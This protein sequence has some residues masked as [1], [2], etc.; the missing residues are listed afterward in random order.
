MD[1]QLSQQD[2][3]GLCKDGN[4]GRL[5][6][7]LESTLPIL[8]Q[9]RQRD[10]CSHGP[11]HCDEIPCTASIMNYCIAGASAK[12]AVVF[13]YLWDKHLTARGIRKVPWLCLKAAAFQG[14]LTLAQTF[15]LRDPDCFRHTELLHV[16]GPPEEHY[17]GQFKIAIRN[18]RFEYIDFMIA[19]GA[20]INAGFPQSDILSMVARCAVDDS[21]T[22]RRFHFLVSRGAQVKDTEALSA[23]AAGGSIELVTFL[24]DNGADVNMSRPETM[25]PLMLAATHG[26]ED[27]VRLLLSR[28]AS[29]QPVDGEGHDAIVLARERG[30][31]G[32][33][34]LLES[35][36]FHGSPLGAG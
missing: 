18:D 20:D 15:W 34:K 7:F 16:R 32:V 29:I 24:L 27:M 13:E 36:E 6:V 2:I 8:A 31:W 33:A 5:A 14:N 23:A 35:K 30:H 25:S 10:L 21:T 4:V 11:S 22:L 28:G 9:E 26:Y 3:H 19:H 17:N 12:Q 1:S